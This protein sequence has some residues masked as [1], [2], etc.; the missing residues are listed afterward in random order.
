MDY[1]VDAVK[2]AFLVIL[3][4]VAAVYVLKNGAYVGDLLGDLLGGLINGVINFV[5][6]IVDSVSN[7]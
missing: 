5:S 2:F 3:L 1:I 6:S 4:V 7:R